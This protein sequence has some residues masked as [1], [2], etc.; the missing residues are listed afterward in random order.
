MM[1][2]TILMTWVVVFGCRFDELDPENLGQWVPDFH[3]S[4]SAIT[5]VKNV[6]Q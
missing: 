2:A 1:D 5:P 4:S 3:Q 6:I